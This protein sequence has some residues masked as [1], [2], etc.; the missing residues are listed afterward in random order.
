MLQVATWATMAFFM[1]G[2]EPQLSFTGST[3]GADGRMMPSNLGAM[4][5]ISVTHRTVAFSSYP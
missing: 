2:G 1:Y 4:G 5:E 3:M